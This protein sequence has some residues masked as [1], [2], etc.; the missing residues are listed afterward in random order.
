[1]RYFLLILLALVATGCATQNAGLYHWGQYETAL[2]TSYKD[3]TQVGVLRTK[4]EEHVAFVERDNKRIAPGLYAELG[5]LYL[6]EGR[7]DL[8]ATMYTKER[9]MWP[10][11]ATL[12]NA[13]L[14]S[15]ASRTEKAEAPK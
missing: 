6:Q 11:S 7:K 15:L 14:K 10:E 13:M 3:P 1:M 8:A 5:T 4:L 12:M 2:Y 9:D